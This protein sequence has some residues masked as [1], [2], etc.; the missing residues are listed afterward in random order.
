[1]ELLSPFSDRILHFVERR[2]AIQTPPSPYGLGSPRHARDKA[3]STLVRLQSGSLG[4]EG[5]QSPPGLSLDDDS[6]SQALKRAAIDNVPLL[7]T[8]TGEEEG[9]IDPPPAASTLSPKPAKRDP[10]DPMYLMMQLFDLTVEGRPQLLSNGPSLSMALSVLDRTPEYETHKIG[11]LY[12]RNA[13]Q[14]TEVD[15][16][17]NHGGSLRYL[18]FLRGLGQVTKLQGLPGYTGGLDVSNDSDGAFALL[19]KDDSTQVRHRGIGLTYWPL[20]RH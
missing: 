12:V 7:P 18:Q 4:K 10:L 11:L 3:L 14:R 17:G 2:R 9:P 8:I 6:H 13:K 20:L 16:L 5:Y 1:M 19:Y 15:I